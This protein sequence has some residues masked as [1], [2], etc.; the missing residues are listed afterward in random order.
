MNIEI[1]KKFNTEKRTDP[2]I[3]ARAT[4]YSGKVVRIVHVFSDEALAVYA[5]HCI[6]RENKETKDGMMSLKKLIKGKTTIFYNNKERITPHLK[7]EK[8]LLTARAPL[9]PIQG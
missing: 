3:V 9:P 6:Q 7:W 5:E 8:Q 4:T 2:T 1:I